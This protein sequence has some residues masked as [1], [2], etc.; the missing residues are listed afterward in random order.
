MKF[1]MNE[2]E[3]YLK[4]AFVQVQKK[5]YK[6]V[7]LSEFINLGQ[8]LPPRSLDCNKNVYN[9]KYLMDEY[10]LKDFYAI[11]NERHISTV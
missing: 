7:S 11:L 1:S 2:C 9:W 4:D 8:F 5:L 10:K 6:C 3:I